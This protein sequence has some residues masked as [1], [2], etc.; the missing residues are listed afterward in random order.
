MKIINVG[1][2]GWNT[3][4]IRVEYFDSRLRRIRQ[5]TKKSIKNFYIKE[6]TAE[7]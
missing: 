3:R 4:Q 1:G 5:I 7:I 6:S 2:K